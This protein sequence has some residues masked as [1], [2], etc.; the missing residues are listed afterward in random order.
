MGLPRHRGRGLSRALVACVGTLIAAALFL[1]QPVASYADDIDYFEDDVRVTVPSATPGVSSRRAARAASPTGQWVVFKRSEGSHIIQISDYF[2]ASS[3][4]SDGT[5]DVTVRTTMHN[6]GGTG[7]IFWTTTKTIYDNGAKCAYIGED[8]DSIA[9]DGQSIS[10]QATFKV[11]GGGSH[12]ITSTETLFRQ[13]AATV[14]GWDFYVNIPFRISAT[15]GT[16]GS[17]SPSGHALVNVGGSKSY[18]ISASSGYRILD[19]RVDG[20]SQGAKSS[21]TFSNVSSDHTIAASFQKTWVVTFK[22]GVTGSTITTVTVDDGK[23]ATRPQAPSHDGWRFDGWDK[24]SSSVRG[25]M[26]VTAVYTKM[27]TVTFKNW[28]GSTLKTQV[29]P[30][31]SGAQAPSNPSRDG[32]TFTGWDK[33]FSRVDRDTVVTATYEP[34]IS[35][36]V[37][38]VLPCR[39]LA[40][41]TV[42]VPKDYAIEN[43]SVVNVKS[44]QIKTSGMPSDAS[45]TLSCD[46]S[47]VHTWKGS[48]SSSKPIKINQRSKKGVSLSVSPVTG[49]GGWRALAQRATTGEQGL[50]TI[51]YTFEWDK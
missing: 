8:W 27:H 23:G 45:Y 32:W 38:T 1:S 21:Y 43:L 4:N 35:V 44:T 28:D 25:N 2:I 41:G 30:N 20:K 24:D 26:T 34:V 46:G 31:G 9:Y 12:H 49:N 33:D 47:T 22:D 29:V 19:V 18:T 5:V 50:C 37:P 36:R 6:Q 40:D 42:V 17:I 14:A 15:A 39:I 7:G 16:G 13:D 3:A 51:S 48:D 11:S 10:K